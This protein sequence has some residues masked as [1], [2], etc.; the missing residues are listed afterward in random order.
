MQAFANEQTKQQF[1]D[2]VLALIAAFGAHG[3]VRTG[4]RPGELSMSHLVDMLRDGEKVTG[5]RRWTNLRTRSWATTVE[6]MLREAGFS[7]RTQRNG[8]A[9]RTYV[10]V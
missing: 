10:G 1:T 9:V 2:D 8:S 4:N 3:H 7:I 5:Y 6:D